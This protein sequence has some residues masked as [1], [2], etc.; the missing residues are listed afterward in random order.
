VGW[1]GVG[2]V[3]RWLTVCVKVIAFKIQEAVWMDAVR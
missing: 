3:R 1:R 2:R